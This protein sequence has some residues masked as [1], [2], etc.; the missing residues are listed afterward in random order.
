M[1]DQAT[2]SLPKVSVLMPLYNAAA[3]LLEAIQSV[4]DQT[5]PDWELVLV[6]DGSTDASRTLAEQIAQEDARIRVIALGENKGIVAALNQGLQ[7]CRAPWIARLDADDVMLPHRL[8]VQLAYMQAHPDCVAL[9]TAAETFDEAGR[10]SVLSQ[11]VTHQAICKQL[12]RGSSLL[13]PTVI[14]QREAVVSAGG[15]RSLFLDAEDYDLWLRLSRLGK[16]ANLE[17]PLTHLRVHEQQVSHRKVSQQ[18]MSSL[19][20]RLVH[21]IASSGKDEPTLISGVATREWLIEQGMSE[22]EIA[23]AVAQGFAGRVGH[24]LNLGQ[25][26]Q[27]RNLESVGWE[28]VRS[29]DADSRAYQAGL[30]W[31]WGRY[32]LRH[33]SPAG[34]FKLARAVFREPTRLMKFLR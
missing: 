14:L 30:D 15:Y 31:A 29:S 6:D 27:A 24:L 26:Q 28:V 11:P 5:M 22:K 20:A 16:L 17:E 23:S 33:Q 9:G 4:R 18:V 10:G 3:T 19:A 34:A 25:V 32:Q 1:T 21:Q 7:A 13:H 8:K 12:E 2:T